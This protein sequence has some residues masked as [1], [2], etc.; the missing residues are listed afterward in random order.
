MQ[1]QPDTSAAVAAALRSVSASAARVA[2]A[3]ATEVSS[4][5]NLVRSS[6]AA[7]RI[8]DLRLVDALAKLERLEIALAS[9]VHDLKE[10]G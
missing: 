3:T 6:L 9:Y 2:A 8:D 5:A 7:E 10:L 4:A 1:V